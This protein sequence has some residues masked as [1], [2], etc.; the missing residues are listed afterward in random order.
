MN[1]QAPPVPMLWS[2]RVCGACGSWIEAGEPYRLNE[3]V[4]EVHI[5]R[6]A[7]TKAVARDELHPDPGRLARLDALGRREKS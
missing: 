7:C 3:V 6:H 1:D 5:S 2:A 4:G